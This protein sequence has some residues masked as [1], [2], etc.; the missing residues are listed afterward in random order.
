MRPVAGPGI[1]VPGV[2][3]ILYPLVL[4]FWSG[5]WKVDLVLYVSIELVQPVFEGVRC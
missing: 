1:A 4:R 3:H 2:V 5:D